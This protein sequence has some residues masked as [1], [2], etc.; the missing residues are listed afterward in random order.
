MLNVRNEA[1]SQKAIHVAYVGFAVFMILALFTRTPHHSVEASMDHWLTAACACQAFALALL[2]VHLRNCVEVAGSISIRMC[3]VFVGAY[4]SRCY[5]VFLYPGYTPEDSLGTG[6]VYHFVELCGLVSSI[7]ITYH[8]IA[9]GDMF[10]E[11]EKDTLRLWPFVLA[12][13]VFAY[14]TKSNAN[15]A[16][17]P[18]FLWM[19]AQ[20]LETVAIVPQLFLAS[21][22]G[23]LDKESSHFVALLILNRIVLSVFWG[24]VQ[25]IDLM[26]DRQIGNYFMFGIWGSNIIHVLLCGDFMYY[27]FRSLKLGTFSI[28]I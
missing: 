13:A 6:Y 24:Y 16:F 7:A 5:S 22:K 23:G 4:L 25:Y 28:P 2:Y 8:I 11:K 19:F 14:L 17:L 12:C 20:W 15:D 9:H 1:K 18:D 26:A 3:Y 21:R 27:Y 10:R